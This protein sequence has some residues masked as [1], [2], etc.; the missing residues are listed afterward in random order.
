[1]KTLYLLLALCGLCQADTIGVPAILRAPADEIASQ[2]S[3]GQIKPGTVVQITGASSVTDCDGVDD[4]GAY[5]AFCVYQNAGL[6][7][8]LNGPIST[9]GPITVTGGG[10]STFVAATD[11]IVYITIPIDDTAA[12]TT[13]DG[14]AKFS[15]SSELNGYVLTS[16]RVSAF[17]GGTTSGTLN[18][19]LALCTPSAGSGC[20]SAAD[21]LSTNLTMAVD[22]TSSTSA[23]ITSTTADKTLETG[24]FVRIDFDGVHGTPATDVEVVLGFTPGS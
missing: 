22:L 1:M 3:A 15:V 14:K 20:N 23:T 2:I 11:L 18:I 24:D 19:D 13:G 21:M 8:I 12:S 4:G 9:P 16:V 5:Y 7:S 6:E 17:T 10:Q